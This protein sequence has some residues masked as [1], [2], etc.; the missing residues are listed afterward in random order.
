MRIQRTVRTCLAAIAMAALIAVMQASMPDPA[1]A[2]SANPPSPKAQEAEFRRGYN[3]YIRGD[4]DAAVATWTALADQGHIKSMNNLGTMY[5]QGKAVPRNYSYA[6]FWYRKAAARTDARAMYNIGIAYE[7]GRG[8]DQSDAQAIS[9]YRRAADLGLAEATN[10][11]AW[12]YAT[13]PDFTVRDGA[14][15]LKWA[16]I[17]VKRQTSS[18][19]LTTLAAAHAEL[20]EYRKAVVAVERAID[21]MKREFNGADMVITDREL[22]GMLRQ[23]GRTDDVFK[24]LERLEF[25]ANGQPTRD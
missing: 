18:K 23:K 24:L 15:A 22:F 25:Y 4:F 12:V 1:H 16:Q 2:Q 3:S 21:Y 5:S 14:Q 8:V 20:G 6:L 19:A 9:W 10:A 7:Y 17:A 13:S 11:I